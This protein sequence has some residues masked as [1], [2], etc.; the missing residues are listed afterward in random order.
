[1]KSLALILIWLLIIVGVIFIVITMVFGAKT[2][3]MSGGSGQIRTTFKGKAGFDDFM[4]RIT[5]I[6]A[7]VFLTLC[8][9]IN[10][11]HSKIY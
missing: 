10:F 6:L 3:A 7:F 1:M 4:S 2:D 11:I 5:L 9:V 8:L